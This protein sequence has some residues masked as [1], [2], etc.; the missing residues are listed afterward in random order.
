MRPG[1][2]VYSW[3]TQTLNKIHRIHKDGI[4]ITLDDNSNYSILNFKT[5]KHFDDH[6]DITDVWRL[7]T[8]DELLSL[9]NQHMSNNSILPLMDKFTYWTSDV[10]VEFYNGKNLVTCFSFETSKFYKL[11]PDNLANAVF[12]NTSTSHKY[13]DIEVRNCT[14]DQAKA[15]ANLLN[16]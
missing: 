4:T 7:P 6:S 12:I 8:L 1:S 13:H 5:V 14:W 10:A 3:E 9:Y 16:N 11:H 15:I 2:V